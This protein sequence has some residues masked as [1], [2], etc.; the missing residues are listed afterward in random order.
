MPVL[1]V[2]KSYL[3]LLPGVLHVIQS[4]DVYGASIKYTDLVVFL[5]KLQKCGTIPGNDCYFSTNYSNYQIFETNVHFPW[6]FEKI[7]ISLYCI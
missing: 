6:R 3:L 1:H 4:I 7:G 5:L 2:P